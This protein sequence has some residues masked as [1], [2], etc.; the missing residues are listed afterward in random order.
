MERCLTEWFR[1]NPSLE[2][3]IVGDGESR[4]FAAGQEMKRGTARD[5]TLVDQKSA[6]FPQ[7]RGF[8]Q[9]YA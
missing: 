1:E 9:I 6:A 5:R 3:Y 2:F 7:R 8:P 4:K